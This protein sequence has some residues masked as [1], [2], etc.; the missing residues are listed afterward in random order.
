VRDLRAGNVGVGEVLA[1]VGFRLFQQML[2]LRGY[3]IMVG[4]YDAFQRWRGGTP[5]PFKN[6]SLTQTPRVTLGL[7][8]GDLVR[9][10]SLHDILATVDGTN[11]NRGLRFDVEMV[12]YCGGTYRVRGRVERLIDERTGSM[13][14]LSNDC[15]LLDGVFCRSR[16]SDRRLFC[17]RSIFSYWREIWLER[18][19]DGPKT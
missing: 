10:K 2:K 15:I 18:V 13:R 8:E 7:T 17:P 4:T 16:Y 11:R 5:Y 6:G 12:P 14:K 19:D 9:V 3:R 1:A